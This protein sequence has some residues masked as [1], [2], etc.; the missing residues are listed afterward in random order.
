MRTE[1]HLRWIDALAAHGGNATRR[2]QLPHRARL[3]VRFGSDLGAS[4]ERRHPAHQLATDERAA[5]EHE[6]RAQ[7]VDVLDHARRPR[8]SDALDARNRARSVGGPSTRKN[9]ESVLK[10]VEFDSFDARLLLR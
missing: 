3:R 8:R 5:H 9:R 4:G 1:R 2:S 10:L 7:L 6:R